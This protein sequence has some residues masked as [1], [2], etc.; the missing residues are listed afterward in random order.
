MAR[1]VLADSDLT[2]AH[3]MQAILEGEGHEVHPA[4]DGYEALELCAA[5]RPDLVF[6]AVNLPVMTGAEVSEALRYDP[7]IPKDLPI[8]VL[9]SEPLDPRFAERC[10][11]TETMERGV[12]AHA[13][14]ERIVDLLGSSAGSG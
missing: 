14:R 4:V 6:A 11:A 8:V 7:D 13:V 12:N 2:N 3:A 5:V 9:H 1:I 10:G